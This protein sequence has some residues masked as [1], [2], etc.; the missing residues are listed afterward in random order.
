MTNIIN[1]FSEGIVKNISEEKEIY[2]R[3][4]R[5]D[6]F[7]NKI[8]N[9]LGKSIK[10]NEL[11]EIINLESVEFESVIKKKL[12]E[13]RDKRK[14]ALT[15]NANLELEKRIFLQI[16]DLLWR[17]HLHYLDH[18]RQ[19]IGLRG[20]AQKDPLDEFKK[21]SFKLFEDLLNRIK[22]DLITYLNNVEIVNQEESF[23]NNINQN[24]KNYSKDPNCLLRTSGNQKVSRNEKCPVTG[25][26]YKHCCGAL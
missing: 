16:I 21:E 24:N 3:E 23:V 13:F 22:F 10:E 6:S 15:E 19:V 25:K 17:S 12:N 5:L 14:K 7:K 11:D 2:K 26:K 20:Y 8:K 4:D 9:T 1:S 18:L